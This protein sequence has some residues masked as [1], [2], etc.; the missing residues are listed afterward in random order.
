MLA[1]YNL[2]QT[3][4]IPFDEGDNAESFDKIIVSDDKEFEI[5]EITK[6]HK[7]SKNS[8]VTKTQDYT[9][10]GEI[11]FLRISPFFEKVMILRDEI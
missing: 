5:A 11:F 1:G 8:H 3:P 4:F 6:E 7:L 9:T 10:T 2:I